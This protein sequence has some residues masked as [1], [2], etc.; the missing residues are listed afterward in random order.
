[1]PPIK[2][3]IWYVIALH[4]STATPRIGAATKVENMG[5]AANSATPLAPGVKGTI[6]II[7]R[8]T[9]AAMAVDI[10]GICYPNCEKVNRGK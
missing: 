1:M 5:T 7:A 9:W 8:I 10:G 3:F 4:A 2:R 6:M